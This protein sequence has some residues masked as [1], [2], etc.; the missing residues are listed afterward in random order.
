MV[1]EFGGWV[2]DLRCRTPGGLKWT[3]RVYLCAENEMRRCT[4]SEK[5]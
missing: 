1:A 5:L 2:R 3:E 4:E